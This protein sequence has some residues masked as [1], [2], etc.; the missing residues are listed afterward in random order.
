MAAPQAAAHERASP[1]AASAAG[2]PRAPLRRNRALG[3]GGAARHPGTAGAAGAQ[4]TLGA[5]VAGSAFWPHPR[6]T[7]P[8]RS[9]LPERRLPAAAAAPGGMG[10]KRL[11]PAGARRGAGSGEAPASTSLPPLVAGPVRC[12]LRCTV[13]RVLWS[14]PRAPAAVLVRL[15]WWGETSDGTVFQPAA[16]PGQ[17]AGRTRARYAVRC[18]ARQFAAY[19]T[20]RAAWAGRGGLGLRGDPP[21]NR[22]VLPS[23][24]DRTE[25]PAPGRRAPRARAGTR[26]R[27]PWAAL[28][29]PCAGCCSPS[30][31]ASAPSCLCGAERGSPGSG[32]CRDPKVAQLLLQAQYPVVA[33]DSYMP[34][35]DVF[36]GSRSGSLKVLLAMGSAQQILALQRLKAEEGNVPA[37]PQCP[38]HSLQPAP[39]EPSMSEAAGEGVMLEHLFEIH[40]ESM[41]GLSALQSTVWGEADCYVQYHFPVQGPV[42]GP[43]Q[44]AEWPEDGVQLKPFCTATTLCVPDPIFHAEHHHSFLLPAAVPVQKLL[45]T[46][47][48]APGGAGGGIQFEVWCRYY[49]P[50]LREQLVARGSLPLSR[51]CAM[52]TKQHREDVGMQT[53]S[54]PLLPSTEA[55]EGFHLRPSG[56]L[57]VSVRYQRCRRGGAGTSRGQAVVLC[58]QIHRAAGLQA[59]ASP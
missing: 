30:G 51:L 38:N 55:S 4:C 9:L 57:D 32:R 6:G 23:L 58:V 28:R 56:L 8:A 48:M 45:V 29:S 11:G 19:L 54:L 41:K 47:F 1:G 12:W 2:S 7:V 50:E 26:P 13:P 52:V 5:V 46:A 20:G 59:A 27:R 39:L 15:R 44:G 43:L 33:V 53:F 18:G 3:C 35:V 31:S 25:L 10:Q 37:V 36:T 24:I 21:E 16:R 42:P 49:Y 14:V 17:A 22:R 40:V 34:V